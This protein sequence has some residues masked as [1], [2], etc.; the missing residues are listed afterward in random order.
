[1]LPTGPFPEVG[2]ALCLFSTEQLLDSVCV[3]L[4]LGAVLQSPSACVI[5]SPFLW[6]PWLLF[7]S[8]HWLLGEERCE[9]VFNLERDFFF[10]S[11][12]FL[13]LLQCC[14]QLLHRECPRVVSVKRVP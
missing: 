12:S 8:S 6:Q 5:F 10:C 3:H 2:C 1:M 4:L 11:G 7:L 13:V 14:L 9:A